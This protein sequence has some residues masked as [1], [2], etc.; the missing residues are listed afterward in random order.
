MEIR[1]ATE[2]SES[3][4]TPFMIF[5]CYIV[6]RGTDERKRSTDGTFLFSALF[7]FHILFMLRYAIS[8]MIVVEARSGRGEREKM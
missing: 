2:L 4:K 8:Q 1:E 6:F 3:S 7:P 5:C